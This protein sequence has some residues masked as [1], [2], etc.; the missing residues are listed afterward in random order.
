M[1]AADALQ[2]AITGRRIRL[3]TT[4]GPDR[5]Q[6]VRF[7]GRE[8]LS[9]LYRFHLTLRADAFARVDLN[10]LLGQPASIE[11]ELPDPGWEA[12][13]VSGSLPQLQTRRF[14]GIISQCTRRGQDDL[15]QHF[16]AVLVP[17]VWRLRLSKRYRAFHQN[18]TQE[19]VDV[20]LGDIPVRWDVSRPLVKRNYC[21]QYG[22]SD[23][24]FLSRLL[25]Q[26]G[27]FYYF[28]HK[29]E[30]QADDPCK[31]RERIVITDTVERLPA[32]QPIATFQ[33]DEVGGGNRD[34]MRIRNWTMRQRLTVAKIQSLDRHFQLPKL[35]V[36]GTSV[37]PTEIDGDSGT[38]AL[39]SAGSA[40]ERT[41][42]PGQF[43]Q[44]FDDTASSGTEQEE[45]LQEIFSTGEYDAQ[46]RSER[47]VCQ[48]IRII[49]R[50]DVAAMTPGYTFRLNG[51]TDASDTYYLIGVEHNATLANNDRSGS[52]SPTMRYE[53]RFSC[54]PAKIPFRPAR[55]HFA[56]K[57][58]GVVPA[59]VVSDPSV[60]GDQICVDRYGRIKV[61]F[62]WQNEQDTRPSCWIRVSQIWAGKRWGAFFWPRVGQEVL[63][64]FEHGDPERPVV[65]G[66]VYNAVNMPPLVLPKY[67]LSCGIHSC[68]HEGSPLE[69]FSAV[70]FHDNP[71]EEFLQLHSE[72]YEAITSETESL[73]NSAGRTTETVGHNLLFDLLSGNSGMGGGEDEDDDGTRTRFG[74]KG[75]GGKVIAVLEAIGLLPRAGMVQLRTGA[76]VDKALGTSWTTYFGPRTN[77]I[78]DVKAM[79]QKSVVSRITGGGIGSKIARLLLGPSAAAGDST[80][81]IGPSNRIVYGDDCKVSHGDEFRVSFSPS[82]MVM[83]EGNAG[84]LLVGVGNFAKVLMMVM[85]LVDL[86]TSIVS[87]ILLE[88]HGKNAKAKS[89]TLASD[90]I[91]CVMCVVMPIL[92]SILCKSQQIGA[93][94]QMGLDSA[95]KAVNDANLFFTYVLARCA[96][97][98]FKSA[99]ANPAAELEGGDALQQAADAEG[100]V[101]AAAEEG[102]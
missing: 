39:A 70:V 78:F 62:P 4:N 95:E 8:S 61:L 97:P 86:L 77:L 83:P 66:S 85:A 74:C 55:K 65:M 57:L 42:Y 18:D 13:A 49:G 99:V 25:E 40:S 9:N 19:I 20:V 12:M 47:E 44:R 29:Y 56:K 88:V 43:A 89:Y 1:D 28:D 82:E 24:H 68:T 101:E 27:L 46:I 21:V 38:I 33:F 100:Q 31:H 34:S 58:R 54:L 26:D 10:E 72:T 60:T 50:G 92:N 32:H 79:I 51:R 64:A 93:R 7:R 41:I 2:Y 96:C 37:L 48:S 22:E 35:P 23:F 15:Y 17:N 53:N 84:I 94:L 98:A 59:T 91:E 102:V 16:R 75:T 45:C 73:R 90:I 76:S 67:K 30:G 3:W 14:C 11:I 80:V 69:N 87:K 52:D 63:V 6:L 36:A 71:G 81:I 5:F